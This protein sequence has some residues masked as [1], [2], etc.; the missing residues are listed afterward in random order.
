MPTREV[1]LGDVCGEI[2]HELADDFG[3]CLVTHEN[4]SKIEE[5]LNTIKQ[6][7]NEK[8]K[9]PNFLFVELPKLIEEIEGLLDEG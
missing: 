7:L 4:M 3:Y 8:V 6:K 9:D 5:I 2:F 1:D